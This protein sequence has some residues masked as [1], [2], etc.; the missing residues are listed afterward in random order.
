MR[1]LA[2]DLS[3]R[4]S[5]W[6]YFARGAERPYHGCWDKL[7][8]EYTEE[9]GQI[10]YHLYAELMNTYAVMPFDRIYAEEPINHL[11]QAVQTNAESVRLHLGLAATVELF[12]YTKSLGKVRW[13]NM[14][15]WRRHF[16]GKVPKGQRGTDLKFMAIRQCKELG[17]HPHKHDD[18][19]ALGILDYACDAEAVP[20]PWRALQPL[21]GAAGASR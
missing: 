11:P 17:L 20:M 6:A 4:S 14:A 21:Y 12:A 9:H 13:V 18:A 16:L 19:E 10:F 8:S 5:G 1:L 2:L 7:A 15:R 3:K